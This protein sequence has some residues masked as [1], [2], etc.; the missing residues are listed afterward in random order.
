MCRINT[1]SKWFLISRLLSTLVY[2]HT[3]NRDKDVRE[4]V[5]MIYW[6]MLGK[7]E[8]DLKKYICLH[9]SDLISQ[10]A[11]KD[12]GCKRGRVT[13]P[14][15]YTQKGE[16][17]CQWSMC[18]RLCPG[19]WESESHHPS[20]MW[21]FTKTAF[22]LRLQLKDALIFSTLH[23]GEGK[24]ARRGKEANMTNRQFRIPIFWPINF[25]EL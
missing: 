2:C 21:K 1:I 10:T 12:E 6:Y 22:F 3:F 4:W 15:C 19:V 14:G 25:H 24:R 5:W 23:C 11:M 9:A 8:V 20:V 17:K 13:E 18:E 16:W 7:I